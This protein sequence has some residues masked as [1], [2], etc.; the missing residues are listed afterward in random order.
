MAVARGAANASAVCNEVGRGV[1]TGQR[2]ETS[3]LGRLLTL[4]NVVALGMFDSNSRA[5]DNTL[6]VNRLDRYSTPHIIP[7][8]QQLK[9][10]TNRTNAFCVLILLF[11]ACDVERVPPNR[12]M[13]RDSNGVHVVESAAPQWDGNDAWQVST[14]SL[15]I[16]ESSRGSNYE[17]ESVVS[18][19]R[20]SGNRIV[21]A[22][23]RQRTLRS[24]DTTGTLL[25]SVGA[26]GDGPEEFRSLAS[27]GRHGADSLV[28]YDATLRRISIFDADLRY[29]R[30][31]FADLPAESGVAE[32]LGSVVRNS[33][34]FMGLRIGVIG[35]RSSGTVRIPNVLFEYEEETGKSRSL[36]DFPG[37]EVYIRQVSGFPNTANQPFGRKTVAGLY[38]MV[39]TLHLMIPLNCNSTASMDACF[40]SPASQD[41]KTL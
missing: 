38:A 4:G 40:G 6:T 33:W 23:Q 18:V 19:I 3:G 28:V 34:L 39:I 35:I 37:V 12:A 1:G 14:L 31:V 24:Y 21:V 15:D 41:T 32:L 7:M 20:L 27:M 13:V 10:T 8:G 2:P 16:G 25:N 29:A 17:F 11:S 5:I 26:V 36:G 9:P 30:S 22:D